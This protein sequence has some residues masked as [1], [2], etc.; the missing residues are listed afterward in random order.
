MTWYVALFGSALFQSASAQVTA[1]R[2]RRASYTTW[3]TMT[4]GCGCSWHL[5]ARRR[6][7]EVLSPVPAFAR[8]S[9]LCGHTANTTA[10]F[11]HHPGR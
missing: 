5:L 9:H 3:V 2:L 8:L 6:R 4:C 10:R 11:P 1:R 7:L